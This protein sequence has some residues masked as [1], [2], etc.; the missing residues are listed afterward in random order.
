MLATLEGVPRLYI[1]TELTRET[2][3]YSEC[4]TPVLLMC[5]GTEGLL[6]AVADAVGAFRTDRPLDYSGEPIA[7]CSLSYRQSLRP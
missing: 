5:T 2:V 6:A 4:A 3:L 1:C 7:T